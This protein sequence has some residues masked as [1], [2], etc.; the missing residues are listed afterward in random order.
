MRNPIILCLTIFIAP[1]A[2]LG[3]DTTLKRAAY[4]LTVVVDKNSFYEEQINATPYVL[5]DKTI[6][7]Y[8][9][10]TIYIEILQENGTVKKLA[11]VKEIKDSSKTVAISFSQSVDKDSP[12]LTMLKV[13]NPF[14]YRLIY[15]AKIFLL[16][17]NK[18]TDTDVLPVE[19][20]ISGFE[21]WP[22]VITSIVLSD[23]KIQKK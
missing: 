17:K 15:K 1:F 13:T 18:W 4:K 3:Q 22:Q 2:C 20:G 10:E 7:L 12:E 9:G 16:T 23:W 8:P 21:A 5:P 6:Q 19:A 11:A 14:H